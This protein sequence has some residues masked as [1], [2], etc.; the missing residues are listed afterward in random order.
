[1]PETP[2]WGWKEDHPVVN[3]TWEDATAYAEWAGKRLPTESEWEK[4]ARG[5][6]GRKYP[7]GGQQWDSKH[8]NVNGAADGHEYTA[9]VGSFP[10]GASPYGCVDMPGNVLEWCADWYDGGYDE[11][12]PERNPNWPGSGRSRVVR[13][14]SWRDHAS[15]VRCAD[16]AFR[17]PTRRYDDCGFRCARDS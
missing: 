7:W 17:P 4:A 3:V 12:A 5:G 8:C 11:P 2:S 10:E 1:M 16:R 15:V 13:G 14:G 6:D 9:P